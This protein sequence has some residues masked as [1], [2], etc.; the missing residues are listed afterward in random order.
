[1][2]RAVVGC[3][4]TRMHTAHL[5]LPHTATFQS[6]RWGGVPATPLPPPHAAY[7]HAWFCTTFAPAHHCY[8]LPPSRIYHY[9]LRWEGLGDFSLAN[10]T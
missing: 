5:P 1:V 2:G 9:A 8:H 3:I 6:G 7:H 10:V 4:P